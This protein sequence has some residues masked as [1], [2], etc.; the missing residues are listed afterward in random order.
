[1]HYN[2]NRHYDPTI[3]RFT[4]PDPLGFV[5]GPSVYAYGRSSPARFVDFDGLSPSTAIGWSIDRMRRPG[6]SNQ[7]TSPQDNATVQQCAAKCD[8]PGQQKCPVG[9]EMSGGGGRG[10]GGGPTTSGPSISAP[11]KRPSNATTKEQRESVQGQPCVECGAITPNQ[12]A[13]HIEPLVEQYYRNGTIDKNAMR[14]LDAVNS[15]CPTCSARQGGVL[16][17]WS[18]MMKQF[19]GF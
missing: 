9:P 3:G 19:F 17:N 15:H 14:S 5:D 12:R 10:F 13:N 4:Q 16:A 2:W 11:Y 18:K 1:L 8:L 6:Q 7:S